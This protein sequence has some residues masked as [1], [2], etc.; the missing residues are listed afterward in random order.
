MIK[1]FTDEEFLKLYDENYNDYQIA[2]ALGVTPTPVRKRRCKFSLPIVFPKRQLQFLDILE[3]SPKFSDELSI[4]GT[5]NIINGVFK[6][7]RAKGCPVTRF[8]FSGRGQGHAKL[9]KDYPNPFNIYYFENQ[10]V[11]AFNRVLERFP[12]NRIHWNLFGRPILG[13]LIAIGK[14]GKF[15]EKGCGVNEV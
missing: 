4:I 11:E 7:L 10:R 8:R 5:S 14:N 2:T 3:Q 15:V 9:S 1:K 12:S 13:N 6:A